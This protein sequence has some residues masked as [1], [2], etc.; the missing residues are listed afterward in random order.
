MTKN[1]L[2]K[3]AA[4]SR[5]TDA[6]TDATAVPAQQNEQTTVDTFTPPYQNNTSQLTILDGPPLATFDVFPGFADDDGLH[7]QLELFNSQQPQQ[8]ANAGTGTVAVATGP[9]VSDDSWLCL[10]AED[11]LP[12]NDDGAEAQ[13]FAE[14]VSNPTTGEGARTHDLFAEQYRQ[15]QLDKELESL[16]LSFDVDGAS[17]ILDGFA[18]ADNWQPL[19]TGEA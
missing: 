16:G 15:E 19:Y 14:W 18:P 9:L 1:K 10:P 7:D 13:A 4:V 3:L 11:S 17:G 6:T 5:S 12:T 2:A 8:P